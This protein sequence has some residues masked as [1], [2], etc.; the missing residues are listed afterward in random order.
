L[1]LTMVGRRGCS[2]G[3]ASIVIA[4]TFSPMVAIMGDLVTF[5]E[6]VRRTVLERGVKR[7]LIPGLGHSCVAPV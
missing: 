4:P 5:F 6:G 1:S 3:N 2:A 7:D